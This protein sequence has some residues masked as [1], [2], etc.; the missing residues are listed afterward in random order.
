M[1]YYISVR[2][3]L[4]HL[5]VFYFRIQERIGCRNAALDA[6]EVSSF[7]LLCVSAG[8]I[9]LQNWQYRTV[10]RMFGYVYC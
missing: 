6:Y 4:L 1:E 2:N 10:L 9:L 8:D 7:C 3:G 5:F